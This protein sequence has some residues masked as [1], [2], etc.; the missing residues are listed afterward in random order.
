M[1]GPQAPPE[2]THLPVRRHR[3]SVHPVTTDSSAENSIHVTS[4]SSGSEVLS[5]LS[6]WGSLI[7]RCG[8]VLGL[9]P[10]SS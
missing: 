5:Q 3:P 7:P 1:V 4:S 6:P 10:R 8:P 9:E 2:G